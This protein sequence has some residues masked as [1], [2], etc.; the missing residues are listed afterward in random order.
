MRMVWFFKHH[1]P[2]LLEA[3]K[4]E[5]AEAVEHLIAQETLHSGYYLLVLLATLI[6]TPGL[7]INNVSVIIGG[8][9]LAPLMVPILSLAL[10][11]IS[12]NL[13]GVLRSLKILA[14]SAVISLATAAAIT[15]VM[16][17][18]YHVVSWIPEEITPGIY[19]FIAFC[20]GIA[21]AFAWVK[22]N[23]A[24]SIAGVAIAVSL[25]PPLCAAGIGMALLQPLL[26]KNSLIILGANVVG[27]CV[28][29]ILVFWV[30]GFLGA[31][32]VEEKAIHRN[33]KE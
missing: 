15:L 22:E 24:S 20:S 8:M 30:L 33:S 16:A 5:Q 21:G 27:I 3:S 31:G 11:L 9:I 12:G 2:S 23:L 14:L 29:A 17:R 7:L 25:M 28:A 19:I 13:H 32:D 4:H 26:V 18:A 1:E 6:I 10:S